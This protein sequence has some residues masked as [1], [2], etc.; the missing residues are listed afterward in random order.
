MARK[1]IAQKL[2]E[3]VSVMKKELSY[4]RESNIKLRAKLERYED[5]EAR[6][7][8]Q[9]MKRAVQL[10]DQVIWLRKLVESIS[11]SPEIQKINAQLRIDLNKQKLE[12]EITH[13]KMNGGFRGR[14]Y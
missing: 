4:A 7:N 6:E 3:E 1:T 2:R 9:N 5:D 10:E 8:S 12:E 14:D 13:S 11:V